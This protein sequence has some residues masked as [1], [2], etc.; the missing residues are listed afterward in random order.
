MTASRYEFRPFIEADFPIIREWLAQ[1]HVVEWWGDTEEQFALVSGDL[2]EPAMDQFIVSA[3][4]RPFGYVQ[5]FD[6]VAWPDPC[7]HDQPR[8]TRAVD[9]FIGE[10]DMINRG[11]GSGFMRAFAE[12]LL[13]AGAPRVIT[14]PDPDNARAIRAY[15][16]AG[17]GKNGIVETRDG[18]AL[19]MVRNP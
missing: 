15:E 3:D 7:F 18:P 1:P 17:F 19:L 14:D 4:G 12:T 13:A 5:S 16:K 2:S 8:G 6:L 9:Q 11:H 10:P